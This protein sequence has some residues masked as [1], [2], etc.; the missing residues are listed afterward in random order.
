MNKLLTSFMVLGILTVCSS[1]EGCVSAA[2]TGVSSGCQVAYNHHSLQN[3]YHDQYTTMQVDHAI[4]WHDTNFNNSNISV[5]TFNNILVLTGQV[6]T[7]TLREQLT[8][9]A[10]KAAHVKEIY[11]LTTVNN[12]AS[13]LT[14][15]SDSWITTKIKSR[16]IAAAEIDP[17][18]IK[19]ITENGNVY[20]IGTVFP[21]QAEIATDIARET[22]GVGKVVRIFSYLQVTKDLHLASAKSSSC[23]INS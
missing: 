15:V 9:V 10:S 5:S 8:Q 22:D 17:S 12:P 7:Q 20:L 21:D 16:L 14:H 19:V 4:H 11:N 18:Q 3:S 2:V 13:T 1:L 6:P 23:M